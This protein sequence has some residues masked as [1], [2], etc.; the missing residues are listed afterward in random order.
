MPFPYDLNAPGDF[1]FRDN[2]IAG[3]D[4]FTITKDGAHYADVPHPPDDLHFYVS[5]EGVHIYLDLLDP[6]VSNT[7]RLG[8]FTDLSASPDYIYAGELEAGPQVTLCARVQVNEWGADAFADV[9]SSALVMA[10]LYGIGVTG[11][12]EIQTGTLEATT[13]LGGVDLKSV[14][15]VSV[16]GFGLASYHSGNVR[17][18]AQGS[19]ALN[20]GN[21]TMVETG[22]Y[23]GNVTL[24]AFGG[25]SDLVCMAGHRAA[26]APDG[27]VVMEAGQDILLG[28]VGAAFDNDVIADESIR[29]SAGR[30]VILDGWAG[31]YAYSNDVAVGVTVV[32]GRHIRVG[33][34]AGSLSE[35][36]AGGVGD[37][38]LMTGI[39]GSL[40]L[41][42]VS[43]ETVRSQGG[44]VII[45]ADRLIIEDGA[46]IT[47][48]GAIFIRPRSEGRMV[49][50]GGAPDSAAA[51][52]ISIDEFEFMHA[53]RVVIGSPT[54]GLVSVVDN[55]DV[56]PDD[57]T[58]ESGVRIRVDEGISA[59]NVLL[60][61][62]RDIVLTINASFSIN[63]VVGFVDG[64]GPDGGQGGRAL[65]HELVSDR[66]VFT[67]AEDGDLLQG[68]EEADTLDGGG[69]VDT[70]MGRE[71]GDTYLVTAGDVV[72]DTGGFGA[73]VVMSAGSWVLGANLENLALTGAAGATGTGN[74]LANRITGNAGDNL[75]IG[76]DGNDT[77]NG[78]AGADTLQGG[79]D[80]DRLNGGGDADLIAGGTK[81]DKLEGGADADRFRFDTAPDTLKNNDQ[82]L[83]FV[84]ADDT[85]EL[86]N[87]VFAS[88]GIT[89]TLPN[90]QF[91]SGPAALD[92]ND[93]VIH[94]P[95]T[96]AIYYDADG[97]GAGA[98]VQ[99]A[100]VT[101]GLVLTRFDFF[102]T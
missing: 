36:Y 39:G 79:K 101:A 78:L 5:T 4:I 51:M 57:I 33:G 52:Q 9:T 64:D 20:S 94:D 67:G 47:A 42:A 11:A 23:G 16:V 90:A 54:T 95:A 8:V 66:V 14:S 40:E 35:I 60:R 17:L 37:V 19:I 15:D 102:V 26:N 65:V 69:G 13:T 59:S 75:L 34:A 70:L 77:L 63:P 43:E 74:A 2:G 62:G 50:V 22:D 97:S 84:V 87:A 28:T 49:V 91:V 3:D 41:H 29:L 85:I 100:S 82:I 96:G 18:T 10:A 71:G 32:A 1:V 58:L 53:P 55:I 6:F 38:R 30:D 27:Q 68:G 72:T 31:L 80:N 99:F 21:T 46:G 25:G 83:D 89:G 48:A 73:D 44:D 88:L 76:G 93:F 56:G 45:D 98:Q 12:I 7:F 92:A 86:E 61:S 81:N 24:K